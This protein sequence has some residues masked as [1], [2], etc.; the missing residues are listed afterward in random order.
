MLR[1][2]S[3][4]EPSGNRNNIDLM[5]AHKSS[6]PAR[7]QPN[8][9]GAPRYPQANKNHTNLF[10]FH[11]SSSP[12]TDR[13]SPSIRR[14]SFGPN[15]KMMENPY[16][17]KNH[18][19]HHHHQNHPPP[20]HGLTASSIENGSAATASS[21]IVAVKTP[22]TTKNEDDD[23]P[24]RQEEEHEEQERPPARSKDDDQKAHDLEDLT[25]SS[26]S[27]STAKASNC[28]TTPNNSRTPRTLL[29]SHKNAITTTSTIVVVSADHHQA[30]K[31]NS[32]GLLQR[33]EPPEV[34]VP[35][36]QDIRNNL[37]RQLQQAARE[38]EQVH[39]PP[40][41]EQAA[42]L[43]IEQQQKKQKKHPMS[44]R[45]EVKMLQEQ[46]RI[47]EWQLQH[48][49]LEQKKNKMRSQEIIAPPIMKIMRRPGDEST[50]PALECTAVDQHATHQE[51]TTTPHYESSSTAAGALPL[52]HHS[53]SVL[54]A[55]RTTNQSPPA[56]P[57]VLAND[58]TMIPPNMFSD[59]DDRL[60]YQY[61]RQQQ[62]QQQ[63]IWQQQQHHLWQQQQQLYWQQQHQQRLSHQDF[64]WQQQQQQAHHP[65]YQYGGVPPRQY[66]AG[67]Q[68]YHYH[69]QAAMP[70]PPRH[71]DPA[72][73]YQYNNNNATNVMQPP[74][75][76]TTT[77]MPSLPNGQ[78]MTSLPSI[79]HDCPPQQHPGHNNNNYHYYHSHQESKPSPPHPDG[80]RN[81]SVSK[82]PL[83]PPPQ[84]F[85]NVSQRAVAD[86]SESSS[87]VSF[88]D[89]FLINGKAVVSRPTPSKTT[90]DA[91]SVPINK[92]DAKS[93]NQRSFLSPNLE[94]LKAGPMP[95]EDRQKVQRTI[96]Q[97]C[98]SPKRSLPTDLL[99]MI[100]EECAR[101][102]YRSCPEVWPQL[103]PPSRPSAMAYFYNLRSNLPTMTACRCGSS[104]HRRVSDPKCTLFAQAQTC[105][106]SLSK[107]SSNKPVK[108]V[109]ET[110]GVVQ[111]AVV[112]RWQRNKEDSEEQAFIERMEAVELQELGLAARAPQSLSTMVLVG[113]L[114]VEVSDSDDDDD[115]DEIVLA[116]LGQL[117]RD[118]CTS[119]VRF[120]AKRWGRC[121]REPSHVEHSWRWKTD[122]PREPGSRTF[123]AFP[124][125]SLLEYAINSGVVDELCQLIKSKVLRFDGRQLTKDWIANVERSI[126]DD[127]FLAS[128]DTS[129]GIPESIHKPLLSRWQRKDSGWSLGNVLVHKDEWKD[130]FVRSY[131]QYRNDEA[132]IDKFL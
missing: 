8:D 52:G 73:A 110:N 15:R 42:D 55:D 2:P 62:Q 24:P 121:Y 88:Q 54:P 34:A 68:Y 96:A 32:D 130:S 99:W 6:R 106:R 23:V 14:L 94:D 101:V 112:E 132:G 86:A 29:D 64:Y 5:E 11:S 102:G 60:Q 38:E 63:Q 37:S 7:S 83:L 20:P 100:A 12:A 98:L 39:Q 120:I 33:Q 16:A 66:S 57:L 124:T 128:T 108:R 72:M 123:D 19:L 4:L 58:E 122:N 35:P 115:N 93:H 40:G 113:A 85:Y 84:P 75:T 74:M 131:Q 30:K 27:S 82:P 119:I 47:R 45:Q 61:Y 95:E 117:S 13:S 25:Y 80:L 118:L 10:W 71:Y 90:E 126:L 31:R 51:S 107:S 97:V 87:A 105:V 65:Q 18:L 103:V 111:Q 67:Q 26:A 1:T 79:H 127:V 44:L 76:T 3:R 114:L 129:Y 89:Q 59:H 48:A 21:M 77:M 81:V 17:K 9:L 116:D 53:R 46:R 49:K 109:V 104:T 28:C 41:P 43:M 78:P 92:K 70:P 56:A 50:S 36:D 91:S 69:Y 22:T 125:D